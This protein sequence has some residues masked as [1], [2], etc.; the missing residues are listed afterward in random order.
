M[1]V[2]AGSLHL[3]QATGITLVFLSTHRPGED[4]PGRVIR[5]ANRANGVKG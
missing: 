5:F 4:W 3:K 1:Q 2:A